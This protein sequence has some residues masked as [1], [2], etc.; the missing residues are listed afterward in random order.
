MLLPYLYSCSGWWLGAGGWWLVAGTTLAT[1]HQPPATDLFPLHPRHNLFTDVLRRR[2]VAIEMHRVGGAS[3]RA[4]SQVGRV[5][6]HLRQRHPRL[7]DLRP[8]A[9]LLRLDVAA[10]ARQVAHHIAHI[11]LRDDHFDAHHRLEQHGLGALRP[12]P[13]ASSSPCTRPAAVRRSPP[14]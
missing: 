11:V 13:V 14:R 6:E 8:A 2:L 5:A 3:L 1:S 10:P 7:D 4:R 12:R 9:I